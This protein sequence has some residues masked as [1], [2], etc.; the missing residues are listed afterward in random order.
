MTRRKVGKIKRVNCKGCQKSVPEPIA[1]SNG[2]RCRDCAT[3]PEVVLHG[4]MVTSSIAACALL[5]LGVVVFFWFQSFEEE[6]GRIRVNALVAVLYH[7][8]GSIGILAV[9]LLGA[10]G[11]GWRAM[12]KRKQLDQLKRMR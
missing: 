5:V 2:G 4:E 12:T 8:F 7:F 10:A 1:K 9:M 6:G 11:Y 3:S